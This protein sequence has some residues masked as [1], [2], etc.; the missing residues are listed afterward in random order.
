MKEEAQLL[1]GSGVSPNLQGIL[2]RSGVQ[3]ETQAVA[4]DTAE[5]AIF[6]AITKVQTATGFAAD[7]IV[8]NPA[9]YQKLRLKRDGNQQFYGGGFFQGQ[10]GNDA[11]QWQPPLW[12]LRT[13]VTSAVPA[14]TVVVG[15]W[16]AGAK[17]YRKGG[18]RVETTNSKVED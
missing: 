14:K 11:L 16:G 8:I 3:T 15:A 5:E 7:G 13:I 17:G 18:I 6:R 2:L 10:Y 4:P 1:N 12:G 9:D